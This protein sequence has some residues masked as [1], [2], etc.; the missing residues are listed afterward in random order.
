MTLSQIETGSANVGLH[1]A[2][3]ATRADSAVADY[4]RHLN[5]ELAVMSPHANRDDP[6][7]AGHR[8]TD[9]DMRA[10]CA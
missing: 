10:A 5:G 6:D 1:A 4:S 2:T 3:Q 7:L 8:A 9:L